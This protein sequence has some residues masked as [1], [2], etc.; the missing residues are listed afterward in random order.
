MNGDAQEPGVNPPKVDSEAQEGAEERR[1]QEAEH[2]RQAQEAHKRLS[3]RPNVAACWEDLRF[4]EELQEK[5]L[6]GSND[7]GKA[8]IIPFWN[9]GRVL[10]LIH[11]NLEGEPEYSLPREE[12]FPDGYRPLFVPGAVRGDVFLVEG[13]VDALVTAALGFDAVAVGETN[14]SQRQK[15]ELMRLPGLIY[16]VP[17]SDEESEKAA[18]Q[19]V[20]DLYPKALLCPPILSMEEEEKK[21][22]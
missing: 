7:E 20:E 4:N 11:R 2:L 21:D 1:S 19:W 9:K 22:D 15:E 14:I 3:E 13:Y 10:G 17:S 6:L 5:F 12:E 16:I 8:A 18:R